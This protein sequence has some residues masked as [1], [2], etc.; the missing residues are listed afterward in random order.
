[1]KRALIVVDPQYDFMP[2]GA[3]PVPG[4]NEIVPAVNRLLTAP[5]DLIA[6]SQD[7]HPRDH[8]SFK[9]NG[10]DWPAHCIRGTRGAEVHEDIPPTDA[11]FEPAKGTWPD[12]DS[13]SAFG[14]TTVDLARVLRDSGAERVYVCGLATDYCVKATVIDALA[15]GYETHIIIDACR[16]VN[17]KPGDSERAITVMVNSG[18][19]VI[20][21]KGVTG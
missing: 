2:G 4:G 8:C 6:V 5:W 9:E 15:E 11:W 3:L 21:V 13:Y 19:H 18:A 16:A 12:L 1:M 14:S 20:T 17:V 7:W 10:G